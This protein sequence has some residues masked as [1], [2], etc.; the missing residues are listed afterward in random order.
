[1]STAASST[2]ILGPVRETDAEKVGRECSELLHNS[3]WND[4]HTNTYDG[5]LRRFDLM[6]QKGLPNMRVISLD[7]LRTLGRIPR[8]NERKPG[9]NDKYT[10]D[11]K[12]AVESCGAWNANIPRAVIVFFSHRWL[13]PNYCPQEGKDVGDWQSQER[14]SL[15]KRCPGI[16]IGDPDD[17]EHSKAVAL[18]EWAEWLK[19]ASRNKISGLIGNVPTKGLSFRIIF[20]F[21]SYIQNEFFSN[22]S[23]SVLY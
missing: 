3:A 5:W 23:S 22:I 1:M 14:T 6:E 7:E 11:A 20:F 9:S 2:P 10:L 21:K 15:L 12:K 17:G 4:A 18:M 8:S 19:V 13:R 16:H